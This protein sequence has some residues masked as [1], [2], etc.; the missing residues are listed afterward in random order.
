M[1]RLSGLLP[2]QNEAPESSS[3]LKARATLAWGEAPGQH[4]VAIGGLKARANSPTRHK[5]ASSTFREKSIPHEPLIELHPILHKHR[6]HLGLEIPP[7]MVRGLPTSIY[8]TNAARSLNPPENAAYPRCQLNFANSDPF[9]LIHLD[10][11]TLSLSTTRDTD[12]VRA[13]NRAM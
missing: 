3:V 9:V 13:T 8:R 4:H 7:L 6:P 12:S 11:E 10:E 2:H 1:C 5:L